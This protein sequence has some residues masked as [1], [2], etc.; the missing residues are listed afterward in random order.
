MCVFSSG[1]RGLWSISTEI[2][3]PTMHSHDRSNAHVC[4][5]ASFSIRAYLVSVG[6]IALEIEETDCL[7]LSGWS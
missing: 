1:M 4:S 3:F 2:V 5:K 6:V 7:K